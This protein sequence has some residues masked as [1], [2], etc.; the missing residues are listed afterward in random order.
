MGHPGKAK[1]SK[2]YKTLLHCGLDIKILANA[3]LRQGYHL[4]NEWVMGP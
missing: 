2:S 3:V 4:V 1:D